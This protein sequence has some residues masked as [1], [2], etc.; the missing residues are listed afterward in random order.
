MCQVWA[1][2]VIGAVSSPALFTHGTHSWKAGWKQPLELSKRYILM[3]HKCTVYSKTPRG[4]KKRDTSQAKS[5]CSQVCERNLPVR[6]SPRGAIDFPL[7][8]LL[9]LIF[10]PEFY[11][12]RKK[13]F[14]FL[15]FWAIFKYQKTWSI[16]DL[17]YGF[18]GNVS[19]GIQRV[20][21]SGRDSVLL[22][23]SRS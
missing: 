5:A 20:V 22:S 9:S 13:W 12:L 3:G 17:L 19:C 14:F 11:W 8:H 1:K 7:R 16:N 18:R 6:S 15:L 10:Q 4:T 21:P 2:S 23:R